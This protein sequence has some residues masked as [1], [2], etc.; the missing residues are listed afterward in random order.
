[1]KNTLIGMVA[2][3][4][5]QFK[6]LQKDKI[7]A[8]LFIDLTV[9]FSNFLKQPP[10]LGHFVPTNEK[11]EVLEKPEHY[12]LF[13]KY[14]SFTQFGES[15]VPKC[16]EYQEAL[17]RCIFEGFELVAGIAVVNL[18]TKTEI[19][20]K[21]MPDMTIESIVPYGLTLTENQSIKLG[22]Q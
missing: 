8:N 11:G 22:L 14:G 4:G 16:K 15:I 20:I 2:F 9:K 6:S 10:L 21:D 5:I 12:D 18:D 17:S 7:T 19:L 3:V 1:M 13:C